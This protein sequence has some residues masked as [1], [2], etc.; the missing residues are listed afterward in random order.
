MLDKAPTSS[1]ECGVRDPEFGRTNYSVNVVD[2]TAKDLH[3]TGPQVSSYVCAIRLEQF[4]A[5]IRWLSCATT[6]LCSRQGYKASGY[7]LSPTL[8]IPHG[9]KTMQPSI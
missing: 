9:N 1:L 4:E 2:D 6:R 3:A 7:L 5:L 8:T